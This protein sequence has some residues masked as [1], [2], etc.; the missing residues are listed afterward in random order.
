MAWL[1]LLSRTCKTS[2]TGEDCQND[3]SILPV[4]PETHADFPDSGISDDPVVV[5]M[6]GRVALECHSET[7][8]YKRNGGK[9]RRA[10]I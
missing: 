5:L 8:R 1:D 10:R 6:V 3:L 2:G 7:E 9:Q 4:V